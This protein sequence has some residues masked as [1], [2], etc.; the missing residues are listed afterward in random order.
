[1]SRAAGQL[2]MHRRSSGVSIATLDAFFL[3]RCFGDVTP[4][5]ITSTLECVDVLQA[6]RPE[7][8]VSII[9]VDPTSSFPSEATRRAALEAT[10]KTS[11]TTSAMIMVV[12]GDGFWASAIRGILMTIGSLSQTT[13]ARKILRYEAEAVDFAIEVLGESP[14]K[15]RAL[16]L[17]SLAQLK[18]AAVSPP[19][20]SSNTPPSS[21]VPPVGSK[22]PPSSKRRAG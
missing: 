10:R 21:R 13:Y 3:M 22:A 12:L 17:S 1:M 7:G 6:Y 15:Y 11:A 8:S 18:S 16:L 2:V 19:P 9:V 5:D 4:D 20:S 14:P